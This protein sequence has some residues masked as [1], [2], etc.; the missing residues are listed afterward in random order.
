MFYHCSSL[1]YIDCRAKDHYDYM[2]TSSWVS[3]VA[4]TGNFYRASESWFWEIGSDGIPSGWTVFPPL[5]Y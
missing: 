2:V 5:H 4:A 3:G 1:N